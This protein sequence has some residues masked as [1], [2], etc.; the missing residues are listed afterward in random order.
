[1]LRVCLIPSDPAKCCT[2]TLTKTEKSRNNLSVITICFAKLYILIRPSA[3]KHFLYYIYGASS[4]KLNINQQI[5]HINNMYN[6]YLRPLHMFQQ[7]RCH[8]QGVH[9][10]G[11]QELHIHLYT[12][13]ITHQKFKAYK[14]HSHN[15]QKRDVKSWKW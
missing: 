4:H 12:D 3:N 7:T 15:S 8:L 13:V 6:V 1:M 9:S 10:K 14:S 5:H 11:T 2:A